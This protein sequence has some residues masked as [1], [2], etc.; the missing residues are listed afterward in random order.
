[1]LLA[2]AGCNYII[3]VPASDDVMLNYQTNAF[4]DAAAVREILG[5][6][7]IGE[8]EAWL[9]KRGVL[10]RGKLTGRAGDLTIFTGR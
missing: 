7:P 6:R 8:F 10:E 9:E 4:H 2:A 1:M 5:L 3:G